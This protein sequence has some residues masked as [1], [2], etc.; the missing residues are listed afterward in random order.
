MKE[1]PKIHWF[2]SNN[3][4]SMERVTE[5]TFTFTILALIQRAVVGYNL[6]FMLAVIKKKKKKVIVSF[7][8]LKFFS[9]ASIMKLSKTKYF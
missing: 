5:F 3:F 4:K 1:I 2:I 7:S 6:S 9:I 8:F